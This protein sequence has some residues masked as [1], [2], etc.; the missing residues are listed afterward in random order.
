M[1]ANLGK[2]GDGQAKESTAASAA[3]AGTATGSNALGSS[4]IGPAPN[5]QSRLK[6]KSMDE[7]ITRWASDLSK[8]QKEFQAQA[9]KVAAWDRMLLEN[10][11]VISKLYS[12]TFQAERDTSEVQKQLST[13]ETQQDELSEW[14]DR[15]ERE[16]DEMMAR[17]IGP[18]ESLQGPDQ[19]RERT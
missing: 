14:L 15:Y 9:D 10:G 12:K 17:Q 2:P 3:P 7:I 11:N 6:N 16:V 4:T 1:F 8:Y 18:G 13:V 5:A 19:D